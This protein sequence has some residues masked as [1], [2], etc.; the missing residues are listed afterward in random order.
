MLDDLKKIVPQ[1]DDNDSKKIYNNI[2]KDS[3]KKPKYHFTKIIIFAMII[4]MIIPISGLIIDKSLDKKTENEKMIPDD[5]ILPE[6]FSYKAKVVDDI[7]LIGIAV[8]S[9]F[10]KQDT[11][12]LSKS[13]V[14]IDKDI[15]L[16][17]DDLKVS[18]PYDYIKIIEAYKFEIEINDI[19]N[20]KIKEIIENSC[21]LGKLEVVVGEFETYISS[22]GINIPAVQDTLIS[23]RGYN[24]YYTILDDCGRLQN[25]IYTRIFSSHKKLT[26]EE[27]SKDFTPPILSIILEEKED[28]RCIY[29]EI[30]DNIMGFDYN[31]EIF[32]ISTSPIEKVSRNTL[33]DVMELIK[34][35]TKTINATILEI[36]Y[37]DKVIKVQTANN[38][39]YVYYENVDDI[40]LNDLRAGDE[41]IVEYDDYFDAY[42]PTTVNANSINKN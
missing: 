4:I 19:P 21:G 17:S 31:T 16:L 32:Y 29:F 30:S 7:S 24:G 13:S 5:N 34:L 12:K 25:N 39:K 20:E 40:N 22:N 3:Q 23:L 36:N 18:Y 2:T 38:L 28:A 26:N 27:V 35:P 8:F 15:C 9:E 33:Y 11:L 41:I 37:D 42:N 1:M 10:D 6:N 14:T